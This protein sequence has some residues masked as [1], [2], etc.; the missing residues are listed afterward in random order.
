MSLN[1][2]KDYLQ[3]NKLTLSIEKSKLMIIH[4]AQYQVY[5]P[6]LK[7]INIQIEHITFFNFLGIILQENLKWE[8][9]LNPVS[10]KISKVIG[11][12]SKL[13]QCVPRNVLL[14]LY[15]NLI[16]PHLNDGITLSGYSNLDRIFRIKKG[17]KN[18]Y[19]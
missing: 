4:M 10:N 8:R 6:T 11:T 3:L 18:N 14:T 5:P 12:I 7:M 13:T 9:H 17:S 1:S 2:Q 19:K 15:N 16:C